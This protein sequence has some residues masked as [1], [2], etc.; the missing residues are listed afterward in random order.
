MSGLVWFGR[1][2]L[3]PSTVTAMLI[4]LMVTTLLQGRTFV[5]PI[6]PWDVTVLTS[7]LLP[8]TL[9]VVAL[10]ACEPRLYELEQTVGHRRVSAARF[11]W[12]TTLLLGLSLACVGS[13]AVANA[14]PLGVDASPSSL[15]LSFASFFSLGLVGSLLLGYDLGWVPPC[16]LV[17]ALVFFGRDQDQVPRA[18][19][20]VLHDASSPSPWLTT[21]ALAVAAL[22]YYWRSDT[23]GTLRPSTRGTLRS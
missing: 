17:T 14:A 7:P 9:A 23:V 4:A 6:V 19:A 21:G 10:R 8:V 3:T 13:A 15:G 2:R 11:A 1:T 5:A 20:W 22:V 12:G 18:W 16:V